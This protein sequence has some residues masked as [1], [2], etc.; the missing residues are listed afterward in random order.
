MTPDDETVAEAEAPA[1]ETF[2]EGAGLVIDLAGVEEAS[3]ENM[4]RGLYPAVVES[5]EYKLSK[6]AGQPMWAIMW[7]ISDGDYSNRKQFSNLSFS[8]KALPFT[9]RNISRFAPELL[10]GPFDPKKIADEI[11]KYGGFIPGIR[12]GEPTVHYLNK[13]LSR[14]TLVGA[15]F[16]GIIAILP[17]IAQGI[18]GVATMSLGGTGILIVVSVV[19]ETTRQLESMMVMRS[20]DSYS[21]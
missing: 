15:L 11:K 1:D 19:L 6:S 4:P 13:I 18:T 10:E 9:K 2:E 5:L 20:Y 8:E 3:F 14:I 21:K 17:S 12:P 7:N 16:L